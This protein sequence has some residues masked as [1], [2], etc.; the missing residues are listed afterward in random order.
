MLI[1]LI[2][3]NYANPKKTEKNQAAKKEA[4]VYHIQA[5]SFESTLSYDGNA[6]LKI[7]IFKHNTQ[8]I[9]VQ[10]LAGNTSLMRATYSEQSISDGFNLAQ[11]PKGNYTIKISLGEE[12]FER[13][14]IKN[15]EATIF[16]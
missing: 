3:T 12:M 14:I 8:L 9:K 1:G 5:Q 6:Y 10:I 16:E 7:G 13:N 15:T 4:A 11:L 2:N